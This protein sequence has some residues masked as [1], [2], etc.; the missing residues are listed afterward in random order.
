VTT[1]TTT[2]RPTTPTWTA[3][4]VRD[5]PARTI[6]V[7]AC[8]RTRLSR[9]RVRYP[10][11]TDHRHYD[12]ALARELLARTGELP[13]SKHDLIVVLTDYRHAIH[14]LA[15]TLAAHGT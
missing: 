14:D 9:L 10:D 5:L 8:A 12:A 4:M 15:T 3:Q 11:H 13:S 1:T 6:A 2:A 7:T